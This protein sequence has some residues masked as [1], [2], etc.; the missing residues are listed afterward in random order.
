MASKTE[1][2]AESH[3]A[4]PRQ[5]QRIRSSSSSSEI[6]NCQNLLFREAGQVITVLPVAQE[7]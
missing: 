5:N 7:L 3:R 2:D 4:I 1:A 6:A